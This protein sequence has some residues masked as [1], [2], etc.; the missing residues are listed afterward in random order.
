MCSCPG[1]YTEVRGD[2]I[3]FNAG[4]ID[5]NVIPLSLS[6]SL[7]ISSRQKRVQALSLR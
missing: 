3:D 6:I 5:L 1:L 2:D 7:T 4:D